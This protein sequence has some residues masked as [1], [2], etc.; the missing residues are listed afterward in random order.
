M[1]ADGVGYDLT[2]LSD[3]VD[4]D[5]LGVLDELAYHHGVLLRYI[6]CEL[7]EAIELLLIGADIHRCPREDVAGTYEYGEAHLLDEAVNIGEAGELPPAGLVDPEAVEH[8]GELMSVLGVINVLGLR[9][10]DGDALGVELEGKIIGDL[11]A[12]REDDTARGL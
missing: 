10:E 4:L 3:G 2:A 8:G 1:L 11:S 7:E 12:R 9:P 6:G 5:L